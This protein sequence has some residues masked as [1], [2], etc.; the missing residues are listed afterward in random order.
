MADIFQDPSG[1]LKPCELWTCMQRCTQITCHP[2]TPLMR[3]VCFCNSKCHR[4]MRSFFFLHS[5]GCG[6]FDPVIYK[7]IISLLAFLMK[8]WPS[9]S[10]LKGNPLAA[11]LWHLR[12]AGMAALVLCGHNEVNHGY[13]STDTEDCDSWRSQAHCC[14]GEVVCRVCLQRTK[15]HSHPGWESGE[16]HEISIHHLEQLAIQHINCL[17]LEFS[18]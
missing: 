11:S 14:D 5:S 8:S 7:F 9:V 15:C 13:L 3:C 12:L 10:S 17:S 16:W 4:E 6:F 18:I 1:F 2:L